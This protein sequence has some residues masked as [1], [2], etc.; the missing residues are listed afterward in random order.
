[1]NTLYTLLFIASTAYTSDNL[2]SQKIPN[3]TYGDCAQMVVKLKT[4]SDDIRIRFADC[5]PQSELKRD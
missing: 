1:M 5:I 2:T 4:Q 3:L